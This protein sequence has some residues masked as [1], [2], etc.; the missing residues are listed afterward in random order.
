MAAVQGGLHPGDLPGGGAV[1]QGGRRAVQDLGVVVSGQLRD[2]D[3]GGGELTGGGVQEALEHL[4]RTAVEGVVLGGELVQA[5][6]EGGG[7]VLELGRAGLQRVR[8]ALEGVRAAGQLLHTGGQPAGLLQQL[9]QAV[10]EPPGAVQ[11][12]VHGILQLRQ[13]VAQALRVRE[14]F[15]IQPGEGLADGGGE[16]GFQPEIRHVGGDLQIL[17]EVE[18]LLVQPQALP[19]ARQG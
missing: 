16:C 14:L 12:L 5:R 1:A 11:E 15:R 2:L 8:P 10:I 19:H 9:L 3:P 17:G 18:A 6:L 7:S 13:G 4:L